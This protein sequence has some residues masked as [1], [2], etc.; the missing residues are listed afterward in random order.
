MARVKVNG[1]SS[2]KMSLERLAEIPDDVTD[3][4][5]YA[6]ARVAVRSIR[7]KGEAYHVKDTGHTLESLGYN[8]P[9]RGKNGDKSITITFKGKRAD[10]PKLRSAEIAFYNEYGVPKRG[11]PPRPF[12]RDGVNAA[13]GDINEAVDESYQKHFDKAMEE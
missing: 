2:L 5:L 12:V 4:M 9:R 7:Q 1:A 6:G 3:A 13:I 10:R 8:K 11:I